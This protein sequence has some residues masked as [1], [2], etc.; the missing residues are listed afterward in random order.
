MIHIEKNQNIPE[1]ENLKVFTNT[2]DYEDVDLIEFYDVSNPGMAIGSFQA[3]YIKYGSLVYRC[4]DNLEL[5]REILKM[6]PESTHSAASYVRMT[7]EL[8]VK[9]NN[10]SLEP[11]SLDKVLNIEREKNEEAMNESGEDTPQEDDSSDSS[12]SVT[13]NDSLSEE[14]ID[15]EEDVV[16]EDVSGIKE[17]RDPSITPVPDLSSEKRVSMLGRKNKKSIA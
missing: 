5:G 12:E 7:D 10:G 2:G 1:N 17:E 11:D 3:Q 6:D 14:E 16:D 13:P 9:M 8:L 4:N 15:I